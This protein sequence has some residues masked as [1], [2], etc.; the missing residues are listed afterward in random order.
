MNCCNKYNMCTNV[1]K[2]NSLSSVYLMC[3]ICQLI[4]HLAMF[5]SRHF[6]F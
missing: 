4:M 5:F 2:C 6:F 1:C 3:S